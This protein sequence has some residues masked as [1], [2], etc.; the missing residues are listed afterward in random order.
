MSGLEADI[1]VPPNRPS[2]QT[3]HA[4]LF[5]FGKRVAMKT[6]VSVSLGI[7]VARSSRAGRAA[8]RAVRHL[9]RIGTDGSLDRAI[10]RLRELD[11]TVDAIGLGGIDVYLYAGTDRYAL[12]D[13]LR[14]LDAVKTTPVVDGSGLK[15]TLERRRSRTPDGRWGWSC[16]AE[17]RADG[18]RARPVRDGAGAGRKPA[19]T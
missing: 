15:N 9:A 17:T 7:V 5:C 18:Q 1:S 3:N 13:G 12:R 16:A 2:V 19:P 6:V 11:G 14:L 10:A 4:R 8:G